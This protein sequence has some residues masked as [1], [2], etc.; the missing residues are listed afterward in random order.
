MRDRSNGLTVACSQKN[1]GWTCEKMKRFGLFKKKKKKSTDDIKATILPFFDK[2]Y[3]LEFNPDV[4]VGGIDPLHHY[5]LHGWKEGRDPSREFSTS[6]YLDQNADVMSAGINPLYHYVTRGRLEGR[7]PAP[8][9][10]AGRKTHSGLRPELHRLKIMPRAKQV[11]L[12]RSEGVDQA[13]RDLHADINK[14]GIDPIEHFLTYGWLE[15]RRPL[16]W[17]DTN[18]YLERHPD[19]AEHNICPLL[20][21]LTHGRA[22]GEATMRLPSL[23]LTDALAETGIAD[24]SWW[25]LFNPADYIVLNGLED[26]GLE[27]SEALVHFIRNGLERG[28]PYNIDHGFDPAFYRGFYP[29]LRLSSDRDAIRHWFGGGYRHGRL[30]QSRFLLRRHGITVPTLPDNFLDA[31]FGRV[32]A[33]QVADWHRLDQVL[34]GLHSG[35]A[36]QSLFKPDFEPAL[37]LAIRGRIFRSDYK[38]ARAICERMMAAGAAGDETREL[39]ATCLQNTGDVTGA[40]RIFSDLR[41]SL[42][43]ETQEIFLKSLVQQKNWNEVLSESKRILVSRPHDVTAR[44]A[45]HQAI[46]QMFARSH[47]EAIEAGGGGGRQEA[48][49]QGVESCTFVAGHLDAAAAMKA[50]HRVTAIRNVAIYTDCTL[51]QCLF[52][53]V[54]QK[55]EH[56]VAGGMTCSVYIGDGERTALL[57]NA[58][59]FDAVIFYRIGGSPRNIDL[60]RQ[61]RALGLV[62][63]Y[64]ID[65]LIFDPAV[66]PDTFESYGN[67][68]SHRV[69]GELIVGTA[70]IQAAMQ[71]CDF[72]LASTPALASQMQRYM[73]G[74]VFVHRNAFGR[75][76]D[77]VSFLARRTAPPRPVTLFYG[78][79]TK[80]HN[81]DFDENLAPALAE[82][83]EKHQHAVRL[84]IVGYLTLPPILES[85][86]HQIV[87]ID[88]IWDYRRYWRLLGEEADINLSVLGDTLVNGCKSEIKWLEAAMFAIPSVVSATATFRDLIEAGVDGFVAAD[89]AE[90][91]TC[92]DRL[93]SDGSLRVAIGT[94]AKRKADRDYNV[95]S[96][97]RNLRAI[98]DEALSALGAAVDAKQRLRIAV[99]NV[100]Y[101][102]FRVGGATRVVEDNVRDLK[103]KYGDQIEIEV[104]TSV[105][106]DLDSPKSDV[107]SSYYMLNEDESRSYIQDG[108]P[109][110]IHGVS[111]HKEGEM[112]VENRGAKAGFARFLGRFKPHAIHF[113]CIQRLT[114]SIVEAAIEAGIPY[115]VTA[116]DGWW[117]SPN[118]FILDRNGR[119]IYYN[120]DDALQNVVQAE[121]GGE[122]GAGLKQYERS[123]ALAFALRRAE[124]VFAV[125][126]AFADLYRQRGFPAEAL[127]NGVSHFAPK[128]RTPSSNGKIRAGFI[129]GMALHKGYNHIRHVLCTTDLRNIELYVV[130]DGL[131]PGTKYSETWGT[132]TVTFIPK[133]PSSE[134]ESLYAE[135]DVLLAPSIWP[136]SFGLVTREALAAGLWVI[137]SN[138]GALHENIVEGENGFVVD[139]SNTAGLRRALTTIDADPHRYQSSPAFV[140]PLRKAEDQADELARIYF[141]APAAGAWKPEARF[142]DE[143]SYPWAF[144]RPDRSVSAKPRVLR[145]IL[146][147]VVCGFEHSGTTMVSEI[148]RQHPDLD[149][150]FE[151]GI[152]LNDSPR[153][154]PGT[155]PFFKNLCDTWKVSAQA[156]RE[157]CDTDSYV[158]AFVRLRDASP[159]ISD[160]SVKLFDK[161]PRYMEHLPR[162]LERVDVPA[163]CMVRDFRSLLWSSFR[164]T[165]MDMDAWLES[166]Y[167]V[168]VAHTRRY[169]M[170]A[171][172]ALKEHGAHRLMIVQYEELC[173]DQLETSKKIFAHLGLDFDEAMLNFENKRYDLAYGDQIK[174]SYIH[175]YREKMPMDVQRRVLDDFADFSDWTYNG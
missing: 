124:R 25:E 126:E 33:G 82:I 123:K 143:R 90:W 36:N 136:E 20:H 102:P 138:R 81:S 12:L 112:R 15:G 80:A 50:P 161:T 92:L 131:R 93:I 119:A 6:Y 38:G 61:V 146:H 8:A 130:N 52:Y 109:V 68:I 105:S 149:S 144:R 1:R 86:R 117:L 94:A 83:F 75:V 35:N 53:R 18:Y 166:V 37:R 59:D 163:L 29:E 125:S 42:A 156:A 65:D 153:V 31:I 155:Q 79:G 57:Q 2:K 87:L 88:P 55:A 148:L 76:H 139:V 140:A 32:G 48:F 4:E 145:D 114:T 120:N 9:G 27:E 133:V 5:V 23:D 170:G 172:R 54:H 97:G 72:G 46:D 91:V 77:D 43:H 142:L 67:Q 151:G 11:E 84:I 174:T 159:V 13:Y 41:E 127:P 69:Y 99:V 173:V 121:P 104:F 7:A 107:W 73:S 111:F 118:Q 137:A 165:K 34:S 129:G 122:P 71:L 171:A 108:I 17:F 113:H 98:F 169:C 106:I 158:E 128:A 167:P 100:F 116:H 14:I 30:G 64:E 40:S 147:A 160:K 16:R 103:K 10:F 141:A 135:L 3:Y 39:Y 63:F 110:T 164:R 58:R 45:F 168:T 60:M 66:F 19:L 74:K 115:F 51:P 132:T 89:T 134:I 49:D 157:A 21:Y 26:S 56:L 24:D 96:M 78:T 62:T 22:S 44:E 101:P 95:E 85:Y 28:A 152:L 175:E 162:I 70:H 47:A 150:G 154:F